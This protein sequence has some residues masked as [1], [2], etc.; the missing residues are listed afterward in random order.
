MGANTTLKKIAEHLNISISTVSRALKDHPDVAGE[1]IRRVKELAQM[2]DYEPNA[3]AISLRKQKS[4]LYAI[5]VPEVGNFFYHG[6]IQAVEEEA[7][8]TGHSVLILQSMNDAKIEADNLKICRH[9]NVAGIFVALSTQTIAYEPFHRLREFH[10]IPLLFFDKVP[11]SDAF[12]K[13]VLAD[14]D[15]GY[16]AGTITMDANVGEVLVILGH[17]NLSLSRRRR[18]GFEMAVL[19]KSDMKVRY[20]YADAIEKAEEETVSFLEGD[21]DQ[22]LV[23]AMSD[24]ILCGVMRGIQRL[25]IAVPDKCK[26]LALSAGFFPSLYMPAI[27]YIETSGYKLGK[28]CFQRMRVISANKVEPMEGS[29]YCQYVPGGS[30]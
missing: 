23:F 3:F 25:A 17:E 30:L 24:E 16:M 14:E 20:V 21:P 10:D 28:E 1:T 7:R 26:I 12:H 4:N 9:N 8:K 11:E 13:V 27:S 18:K 22:P 19:A 5:M 15:A 6:F 2:M 29:I